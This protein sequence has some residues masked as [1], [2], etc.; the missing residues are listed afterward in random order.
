MNKA[1][2]E[3]YQQVILE[4]NRKPR[5]YGDLEGFNRMSEG[6]NPL[7]GDHIWIYLLVNDKNTIEQISFKGDGCAIC[8]ASS[9]MMTV[10]LKGQPNDNAIEI[11]SQFKRM[12][13]AELDPYEEDNIL[14]RLKIFSGIWKFPTRVKC[15]VLSWHTAEGA[16]KNNENVA[17]TE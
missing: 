16:L 4:H 5:N 15:A 12:A 17:S 6:Y 3:L 2:L 9:S 7:C 14:G 13:K 8:K 1:D 10:A 11:I